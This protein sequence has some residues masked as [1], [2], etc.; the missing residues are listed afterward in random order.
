[1][2][3]LFIIMFLQ[4]YNLVALAGGEAYFIDS[5]QTGSNVAD[6]I[7]P[8]VQAAKEKLEKEDILVVA[9]VG[10]NHS[11]VQ[12]ALTRLIHFTPQGPNTFFV[13]G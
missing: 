5:V 11:G 3:M 8:V 1:M 9:L 6:A 7:T 10:D 4:M 2:Y 12:N 13:T